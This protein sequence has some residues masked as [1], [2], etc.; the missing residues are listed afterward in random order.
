[1]QEASSRDQGSWRRFLANKL[2]GPHD[3]SSSSPEGNTDVDNTSMTSVKK[4]APP[5]NELPENLPAD[6]CRTQVPTGEANRDVCDS[7]FL[8]LGLDETSSQGIPHA[9]HRPFLP[10]PQRTESSGPSA[11]QE[12]ELQKAISCFQGSLKSSKF[13]LTSP[14]LSH[15]EKQKLRALCSAYQP[16]QFLLL[17]YTHGTPER[18]DS[19][20]NPQLSV[21]DERRLTAAVRA[22][23]NRLVAIMVPISELRQ[24]NAMWTEH[25]LNP[26]SMQDDHGGYYRHLSQR[27]GAA[28]ELDIRL[29]G[30]EEAIRNQTES[31]REIL[32]KYGAKDSESVDSTCLVTPAMPV[33]EEKGRPEEKQLA[34]GLIRRCMHVIKAVMHDPALPPNSQEGSVY[35]LGVDHSKVPR[36]ERRQY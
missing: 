3:A 12:S 6:A 34:P 32:A 15:N 16:A 36:Q 29:E 35:D 26:C 1:M 21:E 31:L 19:S 33:A 24:L 22:A 14:A 20:G 9:A 2:R 28:Q 13:A 8:E 4:A 5:M 10:L 25:G 30:A 11:S 7:R 27:R 18:P 23:A 17:Q